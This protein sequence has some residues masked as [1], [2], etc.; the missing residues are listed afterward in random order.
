MDELISEMQIR[1]QM[2]YNSIVRNRLC[3]VNKRI[4]LLKHRLSQQVLLIVEKQLLDVIIS[5]YISFT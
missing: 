4:F 5:D 3:D 1:G 2:Y